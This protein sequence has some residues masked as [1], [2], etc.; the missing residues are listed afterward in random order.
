MHL[1]RRLFFYF[2]TTLR[3]FNIQLFKII[4]FNVH[5]THFLAAMLFSASISASGV[6]KRD[7]RAIVSVSVCDS[8]FYFVL[9][10]FTNDRYL[11][12]ESVI[13]AIDSC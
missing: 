12:A 11:S 1:S 4:I 7:D 8:Y 13:N 10:S 3:I 2:V 6:L 5:Q 9:I